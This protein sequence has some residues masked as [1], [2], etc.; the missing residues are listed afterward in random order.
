[1]AAGQIIGAPIN[2]V[3]ID[4]QFQCLTVAGEL[5]SGLARATLSRDQNHRLRMSFRWSCLLASEAASRSVHV[6]V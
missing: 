4:L 3:V 5:K 6:G 2:G 1:V